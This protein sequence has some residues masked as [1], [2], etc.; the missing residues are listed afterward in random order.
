M[1]TPQLLL[2]VAILVVFVALLAARRLVDKD[3]QTSTLRPLAAVGA[4]RRQTGMALESGHPSQFAP[5]RG[6]LHTAAGPTSIAAMHVLGQV[7]ETM[8]RG[9]LTPQVVLG[10]ATLLPLVED[11]LREIS[12]GNTE[13]QESPVNVQFVAEDRF[14]IAY[15]AGAAAAIDSSEL[16]SSIAVGRFGAELAL[17]GEAANRKGIEQ[18]MGSDD[19]A[20]IAV[21]I[22][23]TENSLWG[24]EIFAAGAYLRKGDWDR[25]AVLAQDF[26]R[27]ILI[28]GLAGAAT[29]QILGL[30]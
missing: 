11:N 18:L 3:D 14:P 22:A 16:A 7:A 4:L 20:A 23:N 10:T 26:L 9:Q 6:S 5:G 1:L 25:A 24:E 13:V 19:P 17:I 29:A 12:N 21:A 30:T 2:V 28:L 8:G 27:W 15:A